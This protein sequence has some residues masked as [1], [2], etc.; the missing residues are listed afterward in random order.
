MNYSRI[1]KDPWFILLLSKVGVTSRKTADTIVIVAVAVMLLISLFSLTSLF[2]SDNSVTLDL[3]IEDQVM[4]Q[5]PA[6]NDI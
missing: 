3:S 6:L 4:E 2:S 1:P 5:D